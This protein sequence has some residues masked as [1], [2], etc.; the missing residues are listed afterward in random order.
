MKKKIIISLIAIVLL[1][2]SFFS[3]SYIN[4]KR[5]LDARVLRCR[6]FIS[7]AIDKVENEDFA[8]QSVMKALASN[9]YAAYQFCDDVNVADQLHDLWN[10]VLDESDETGAKEVVLQELK[11]T[12][13]Y[14]NTPAK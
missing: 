7:F 1:V 9:I 12:L 2:A 14:Y 6:T 11:S 8:D 13:N 5:N 3:G 10:Y 4:E